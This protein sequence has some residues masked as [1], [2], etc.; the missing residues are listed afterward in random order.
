MAADYSARVDGAFEGIDTADMEAAYAGLSDDAQSYGVTLLA[1][2]DKLQA[3][4]A[5]M[6]AS[7]LE[8]LKAFEASMTPEEHGA[9]RQALLL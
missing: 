5:A 9:L 3:I 2:P 4:E 6:P 8:E 1:Y 7:V